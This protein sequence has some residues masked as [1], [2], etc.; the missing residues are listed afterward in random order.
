[1]TGEISLSGHVLRIGGLSEKLLAAK[2]YE[3]KTV[4]IP[5][6]NLPDL[7]EIP[8]EVKKGLKIKPVEHMDEVL[9]CVGLAKYLA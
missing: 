3:M 1:M 7:T 2:R 8:E 9:E 5:K 6:S 4:I